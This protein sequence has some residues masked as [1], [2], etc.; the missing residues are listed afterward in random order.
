MLKRSIALLLCAGLFSCGGSGSGDDSDEDFR[1]TF[2]YFFPTGDTAMVSQIMPIMGDSDVQLIRNQTGASMNTALGFI[3][4]RVT[5]NLG[6][7][8][9][10]VVVQAHNDSGLPAGSIFYQSGITGA[11]TPG[12]TMTT[13]TGR[14][15]VMN[16]QV[17]RVNIKLTTVADGNLYV[18]CPAGSTVFA[19]IV[20]TVPGAQPNWDG[21]TMNLI[22]SGRAVPGAPEP[23]VNYQVLGFTSAPGP[24]SNGT[25][26]A[27]DLGTVP[28]RNTFLVK[29]TK[30]AFVDTYTYIQSLN[31]D[32]T[33]GLGGGNIFITSPANRDA[34]INATG[35]VLTPGTG[36]VTG[37]VLSGAGGFTVQAR[38]GNDQIVGDVRYG[39]NADGGRP[40]AVLTSTEAD[41]IFYVYNVPPGQVFLRATKLGQAA[42]TYV[43]VFADAI[44]LPLDLSP[45]TQAQATISISG[46]LASLQGFAVPNGKVT[47]HGLGI[48]D[49]SDQFGEY[50][51]SSAPS[52]YLLIVRTSK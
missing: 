41:G 48:S 35:V 20:G 42:T 10:G 17:G 4:G 31:A 37:R 14:F 33:P 9:T 15:V 39:D 8:L 38:D 44:T 27:F 11:Y 7:P 24:A 22:A 45:L 23:S 26:G 36:I 32:L 51:I 18:Q 3:A 28:A 1:T 25:T 6:Q 47:L 12:L 50:T 30:A 34:E 52:Q 40:S 13:P 21:I 16:V 43:D 49:T 19:Q 46:A 29:C 5:N 2:R